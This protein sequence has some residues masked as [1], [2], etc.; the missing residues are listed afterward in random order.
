MQKL[1]E[2]SDRKRDD[3]CA[4]K[5]NSPDKKNKKEPR[6]LSV[7]NSGVTTPKS[8]LIVVEGSMRRL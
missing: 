6:S 2:A 7:V 5:R 3:A 8:L 1:P 4:K